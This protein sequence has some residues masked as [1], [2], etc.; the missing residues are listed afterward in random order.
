MAL[1][2]L[3][4]INDLVK[5]VE[6][7]WL[8]GIGNDALAIE[9]HIHIGNGGGQ[10]DIAGRN[11]VTTN[12]TSNGQRLPLTVDRDHLGS[13]NPE[14]SVWEYLHHACGDCRLQLAGP[15][16]RTRSVEIQSS[17]CLQDIGEVQ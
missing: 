11:I 13:L 5:L 12:Q 8:I 17:R 7:A 4:G 6:P 9:L 16:R 15:R 3:E 10:Y 1:T 2:G 14:V